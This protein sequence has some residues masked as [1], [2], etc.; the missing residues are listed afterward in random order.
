MYKTQRLNNFLE[1]AA[2]KNQRFWRIVANISIVV[3]IGEM[4]F[5]E[6]VLTNN[7]LRF[8]YTPQVAQPVF[9][10]I[11]GV[12]INL[13]W[14]PYLL[15]AIS[16]AITVHEVAHGIIASLEKI[17]VKSAGIILAP[18]TFGG[19]VEPDEEKFKKAQLTSRLRVLSIGSLTN[20]AFGLLASLLIIG[21]FMPASGVLIGRV[22]E[23]G[24][25]YKA[26]IQAWDVIQGINGVR[27]RDLYDM[28]LFMVS[29]K[30]GDLLLIGTSSGVREVISGVSPSN[31][32]QGIIG[33][34]G[35]SNYYP[36]WYGEFAPQFSYNLYMVLNWLSLLMINLAIFNMMPL[37]PLD[38]EAYVYSLLKERMKRGL[39][40]VRALVNIFSLA[41]IGL[42][43]GMT[44]I[45]YGLIQI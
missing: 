11:P 5:A 25:A 22:R 13:R 38:G 20:L 44:F 6:Y 21:L 1:K 37:Y 33:V 32:S 26:G 3:A 39:K 42:N 7:F 36:M 34:E 28:S 43:F 14:F 29:V 27:I 4:F 18:I 10:I 8:M 15:L 30:P 12:T 24:P 31:S 17:P 40:E 35:L 45:K 19:F 9:P 23:D 2:N 41:L 16:L